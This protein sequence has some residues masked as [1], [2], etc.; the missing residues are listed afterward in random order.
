VK[1]VAGVRRLGV[2]LGVMQDAAAPEDQRER[3]AGR[4]IHSI[5]LTRPSDLV[6]EAWSATDALVGMMALECRARGVRFLVAVLPAAEQ[7]EPAAADR[8]RAGLPGV[9]ADD[10]D[11]MLPERRLKGIL[12]ARGVPFV[13]LGDAFVTRGLSLERLYF[14]VDGHWTVE[15][16]RVAG[17]VIAGAVARLMAEGANGRGERTS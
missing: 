3:L 14:P 10:L 1:R 12:E 5:Y 9:S 6:A 7:F 16:N 17:E 11:F 13:S 15:G 2:R 8:Y 4:Q